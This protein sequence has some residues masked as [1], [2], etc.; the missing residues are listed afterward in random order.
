MRLSPSRNSARQIGRQHGR[1]FALRQHDVEP[2]FR[3]R[4][5]DAEI[6]WRRELEILAAL[7]DPGALAVRHA[8]IFLQNAAHPDVGGGLEIGAADLLADQVFRLADA[9]LGVDEDKAVAEAPVQKHRDRGQ[10]LAAVARHVIAADIDLA[11]VELGLARHAPV[12]LAR[13]HAGQHHELDAVGLHG[14][15]AERAHNLVVAA[16]DGQSQLRHYKIPP[17]ASG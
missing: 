14:A 6:F 7:D 1:D 10:R 13:A 12:A 2:F 8:V 9:G 15:V 4:H 17:S 11:D 16:G 5:F 3:R